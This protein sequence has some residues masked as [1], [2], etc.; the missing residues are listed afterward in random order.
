M[1]EFRAL[2][3][4]QYSGLHCWRFA[5]PSCGCGGGFLDKTRTERKRFK[6]SETNDEWKK[7]VAQKLFQLQANQSAMEGIVT[8]LGEKQGLSAGAMLA[9]IQMGKKAIYQRRLER[10]E[11]L[12]PQAAAALD[13]REAGEEPVL[14]SDFGLDDSWIK[15]LDDWLNGGTPPAS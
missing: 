6:M 13:V 2:P 5:G 8:F 14:P 10:V 11:Q 3:A 9:L 15:S 1:R 12:D 4:R 7:S